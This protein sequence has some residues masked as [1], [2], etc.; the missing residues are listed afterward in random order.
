MVKDIGCFAPGECVNSEILAVTSAYFNGCL[1]DCQDEENH[2]G[3]EA[4]THYA[5]SSVNSRNNH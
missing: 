3:C 2:P 1:E 5:N 4:F